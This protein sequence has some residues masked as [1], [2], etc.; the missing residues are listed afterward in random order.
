VTATA[1]PAAWG[2]SD[3]WRTL[4]GLLVV[5]G[6]TALGLAGLDAL[7]SWIAGE[8]RD[9]RL[10][11]S[12]AEAE[13]RL[14]ARLI[15]PGYFPDT[16]AWPPATVRLRAGPVPGVSLEFDGRRGGRHM[17]LAQ[18]VRPGDLPDR[19]LAP[20]PALDTTPIAIGG[21]RGVLRRYVGPDG[22][23]WRELTWRVRERELVLRSRGSV[24]EMV[25]MAR[26]A[27]EEP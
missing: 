16:I 17:V 1:R 26:T 6:G 5:L 2:P 14:R 8:P 24:E 9:V 11:E 22:T 4:A 18:A 23:V 13:R 19:L 27:R 20:V 21:G 7:P 15:L 10:V 12:V 3:V 25:R